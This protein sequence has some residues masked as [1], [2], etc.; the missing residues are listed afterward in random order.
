MNHLPNWATKKVFDWLSSKCSI[1]LSNVPGPQQ[2]LSIDGNDLTGITFWPPQRA[3]IGLF[4]CLFLAISN[5]ICQHIMDIAVH[6][7]ARI[8][9]TSRIF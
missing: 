9:D 8:I 3:N 2:V 6:A 5:M 1:V 7:I 4:S